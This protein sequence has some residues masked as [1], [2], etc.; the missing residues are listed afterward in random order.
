MVI[1]GHY[2]D[3]YLPNAKTPSRLQDK[4]FEFEKRRNVPIKYSR[5]LVQTTIQA[6]KRIAEIKARRERAFWKNR[7]VCVKTFSS[8]SLTPLPL[9]NV[10]QQGPQTHP[11]DLG[12]LASHQPRPTPSLQDDGHYAAR[13]ACQGAGEDQGQRQQAARCGPDKSDEEE[14]VGS[15]GRRNGYGY[16]CRAI[17]AVVWELG[18]ACGRSRQVYA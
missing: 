16:G 3:P 17:V 11:P 15:R 2:L 14:C 1:V 18:R 5:D 6:M 4:T 13:R 12:N 8:K 10:R 7:Y 9:Q